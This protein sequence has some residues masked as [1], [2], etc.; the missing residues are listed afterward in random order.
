[1]ANYGTLS[2]VPEEKLAQVSGGFKIKG[3]EINIKKETV[4]KALKDVGIFV[5]GAAVASLGVG[6]YAL[7]KSKKKNSNEGHDG[8]PPPWT[9]PEDEIWYDYK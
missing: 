5:A 8:P 4:K 3:Y 7:V 9:P 6:I 2:L 1:M